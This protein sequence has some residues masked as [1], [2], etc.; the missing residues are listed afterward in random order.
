MKLVAELNNEKHEIALKQTGEKVS[1]DIDG[2]TY[3][4]EIS[5]PE[6][7]VYLL[8][9]EGKIFEV[10]VSPNEKPNELFKVN[11]SN[12]YFEIKLSD[13]KRLH[14]TSA[15]NDDV[16][17]IAEIKTAMPGKI[18]R[19]LVEQGAEVQTGDGI[20]VVEAMKMQ[21]EMKSPKDGVIKEIRF[22]EGA[23]VNA[24]DVL[25]VIE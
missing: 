4:L 15:G 2:R 25:A 11:L 18:V 1:A 10:F 13:P 20:I 22:A 6:P 3:E 17:G 24:G 5:E 21:N 12:Q 23:T 8:K 9:H 14:G 16:E 7:N 19:V